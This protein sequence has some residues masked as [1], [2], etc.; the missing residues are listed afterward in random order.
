M[1]VEMSAI[2]QGWRNQGSDEKKG[3]EIIESCILKRQ[4]HMLVEGGNEPPA[5]A[6]AGWIIVI[7]SSVGYATLFV[8]S[9]VCTVAQ[10]VVMYRGLVR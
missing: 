8:A 10:W 9:T 2:E 1:A 6:L 7:S 4:R 3:P 5:T